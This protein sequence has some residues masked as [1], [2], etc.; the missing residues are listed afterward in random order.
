MT[1]KTILH[2]T[3]PEALAVGLAELD[4]AVPRRSEG[5]SKHHAERYCIAHL[6]ATLPVSELSFPLVLV[7]GDKPDFMMTMPLGVV[8]IEHSEAV[9]ENVAHADFLREKEDIGPE[10]YFTPHAQ[11][12]EPR[13]TAVELR[14]EIVADEPGGAWIGDSPER[15]WAAAMAYC[16]KEKLPKAVAADFSRHAGNWLLIYDNW[17]LPHIDHAKAASFLSPIL[18]EM[19][20]FGVFDRVFVHDDSRMCEFREASSPIIHALIRPRVASRGNLV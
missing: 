3:T 16:I 9:P 5:R 7:H 2:A 8:G 13:K 12:G 19:E 15:E 1:A 20:T 18:V 17:P 6:L 4:I 14:R 10:A 11:P